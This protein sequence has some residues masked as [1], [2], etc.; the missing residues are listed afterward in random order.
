MLQLEARGPAQTVPAVAVPEEP[1]ERDRELALPLVPTQGSN[2][3]GSTV[4]A[5]GHTGGVGPLAHGLGLDAEVLQPEA[6]VGGRHRRA[7]GAE[8]HPHQSGGH[9][10]GEHA[11]QD[12]VRRGD[13]EEE[14]AEDRRHRQPVGG[15]AERSAQLPC[16]DARDAEA[17]DEL[18]R[19][20]GLRRA[21]RQLGGVTLEA[22]GVVHHEGD[23]R[24]DRDGRDQGQ[25]QPPVPPD[26]GRPH[27]GDR[28]HREEV[29]GQGRE[30][31]DRRRERRHDVGQ[32]RLHAIGRAGGGNDHGQRDHVEDQRD[33]VDSPSDV[34]GGGRRPVEAHPAPATRVRDETE[35]VGGRRRHV[36]HAGNALDQARSDGTAT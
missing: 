6:D 32:R 3:Q 28:P 2:P 24:R 33:G 8:R 34:A 19:D 14:G 31:V 29:V 30:R 9:A 22:Q 4:D 26:E 18:D 13:G 17:H 10:S 36:S 12:P 27:H 7:R 16:G 15:G 23:A 5:R 21:E 20:A 11:A 1:P 35:H 25:S